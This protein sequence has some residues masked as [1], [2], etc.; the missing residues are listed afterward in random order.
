VVTQTSTDR[1]PQIRRRTPA[2]SDAAAAAPRVAES[3]RQRAARE[4]EAEFRT[5]LSDH[6]R[7]MRRR[8]VGEDVLRPFER[9]LLRLGPQPAAAP[10]VSRS[11]TPTANG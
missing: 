1:P 5:L 6:I 9:E 10:A 8:G 3:G 11:K 7:D 2:P 4:A